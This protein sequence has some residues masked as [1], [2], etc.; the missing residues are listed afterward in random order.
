MYPARSLLAALASLALIPAASAQFTTYAGNAD[1]EAQWRYAAGGN[2]PF[3][4]FEGFIGTSSPFSGPSDQIMELPAL[5]IIFY[6][7]IKG[8]WPGVYSNVPQ[9]H[10]GSNQLANFGGGLQQFQDYSI[11]PAT[12]RRIYS[13]GLWQCDPQG[14]LTLSAYDESDQFVGQIVAHVN[15]GSGNSFAGFISSTPIAHVVVEGEEGDGYNHLDDLQ[16]S[17]NPPCRADWNHDTR[18]NSQDFFDFLVSFFADNADFNG[19]GATNSQ[20]FFDFLT[21]FFTGC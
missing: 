12:G 16:V 11:L 20:D 3:E 21:A 4:D 6:T 14:D 19:S 2:I 18:L 9:A 10:S 8:V 1:T 17:T 13:L 15:D 5:G 7:G